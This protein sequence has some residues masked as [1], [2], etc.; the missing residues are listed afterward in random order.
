MKLLS[1]SSHDIEVTHSQS[2]EQESAAR[3]EM[4]RVEKTKETDSNKI[5]HSEQLQY[6]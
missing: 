4:D 6:L 2:Y 3:N 1:E 5:D